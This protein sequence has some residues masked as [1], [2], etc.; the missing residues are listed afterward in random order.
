MENPSNYE[1]NNLP[2]ET[3]IRYCKI[4]EDYQIIMHYENGIINK[5]ELINKLNKNENN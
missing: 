2:Q 1:K 4:I 3:K 5:D